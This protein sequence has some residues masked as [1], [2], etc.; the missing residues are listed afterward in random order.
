MNNQQ[1]QP[2]QNNQPLNNESVTLDTNIV[3]DPN[4]LTGAAEVQEPQIPEQ[5]IETAET[6]KIQEQTTQLKELQKQIT[7]R[8]D[9]LKQHLIKPLVDNKLYKEDEL[10]KYSFEQLQAVN[11]AWDKF[12]EINPDTK[13]PTKNSRN[14][15]DNKISNKNNS[16]FGNWNSKTHEYE[17]D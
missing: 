3:L 2:T 13:Q 16:G 12:Q 4:V 8:D 9:I 6:L 17:Y 11:E 1:T 14:P 7:E 15:D 5:P 10:K